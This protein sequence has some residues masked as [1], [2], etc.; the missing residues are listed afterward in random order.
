MGRTGEFEM[1]NGMENV[2]V[3]STR[4]RLVEEA[5]QELSGYYRAKA[6]SSGNRWGH[7]K[8]DGYLAELEKECSHKVLD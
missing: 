6:Q 8:S 1:L 7:E 3:V 5:Y 4:D 2:A